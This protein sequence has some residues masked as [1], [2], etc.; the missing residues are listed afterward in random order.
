M[1][2]GT[3]FNF[4][5]PWMVARS[6]LAHGRQFGVSV[7]EIAEIQAK[8]EEGRAACLTCDDGMVVVTVEAHD[9]RS[10]EMFVLLAVAYKP[11]AFE[12]QGGAALRAIAR[13]LGAEAIAFQARRKGWARKLG[14][15]WQRRGSNEF[16]RPV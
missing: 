6:C 15:E 3:T 1:I 7:S 8:C 2:A 10:Y 12:R 9:E 13:D 4:D 14:P 5:E 16:V 11:G